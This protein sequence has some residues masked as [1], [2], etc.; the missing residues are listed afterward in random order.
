MRGTESGSNRSRS[1]S[2]SS[3]LHPHYIYI[4][5]YLYFFFLIFLILFHGPTIKLDRYLCDTA[6][7]AVQYVL[8]L[9]R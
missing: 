5:I 8:W 3:N 1:N 4:Y 2:S 9:N 6:E 7:I